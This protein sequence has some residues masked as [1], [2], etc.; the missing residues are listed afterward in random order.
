MVS[1]R[2]AGG[3]APVFEQVL[4]NEFCIAM[5]D[6][7]TQQFDDRLRFTA[8]SGW[9]LKQKVQHDGAAEVRSLARCTGPLATIL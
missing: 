5:P 2:L 7:T 1:S 4:W 6:G 8:L 3:S 9:L